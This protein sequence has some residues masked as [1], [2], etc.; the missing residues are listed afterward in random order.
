M[1]NATKH[2]SKSSE[3]RNDN[4]TAHR[5][6]WRRMTCSTCPKYRIGKEEH[7]LT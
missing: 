7:V 3:C 4:I 1:G 2:D 6:E 5:H